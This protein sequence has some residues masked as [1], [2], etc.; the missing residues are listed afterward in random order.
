M[1]AF[2]LLNAADITEG[3]ISS[4]FSTSLKV[5]TWPMRLSISKLQVR[6]VSREI[7]FDFV[8]VYPRDI[9]IME[10][11]CLL[12]LI[13]LEYKAVAISGVIGQSEH[14]EDEYSNME[15]EEDEEMARRM[16]RG[17]GKKNKGKKNKNKGKQTGE[18]GSDDTNAR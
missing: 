13:S 1:T 14:H 9:K 17:A 11:H 8:R 5:P 16:R 10:S 4:S 18:E 2:H 7:R 3:K 15:G 12:D 6:S